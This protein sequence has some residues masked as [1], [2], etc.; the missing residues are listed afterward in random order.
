MLPRG[1]ELRDVRQH[2][3]ALASPMTACG[4]V[5][6]GWGPGLLRGPGLTFRIVWEQAK[7]VS[8]TEQRWQM[9]PGPE[10]W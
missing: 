9:V 2:Q 10:A 5:H 7:K 4:R 6:R 3:E 8:G 1:P